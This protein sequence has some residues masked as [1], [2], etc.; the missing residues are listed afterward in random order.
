MLTKVTDEVV[1]RLA[2]PN[3]HAGEYQDPDDFYV[4]NNGL[5]LTASFLRVL[6]SPELNIV[7]RPKAWRTERRLLWCRMARGAQP[8][9]VHERPDRL[10]W[11]GAN[12]TAIFCSS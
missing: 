6:A 11:W 2:R 9:G 4:G 5:L 7:R 8:G 3:A 10:P 1:H 12:S